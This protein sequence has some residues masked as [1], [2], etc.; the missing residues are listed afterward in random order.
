MA[1]FRSRFTLYVAIAC[2]AA[3]VLAWWLATL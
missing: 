1:D 3:I 2:G